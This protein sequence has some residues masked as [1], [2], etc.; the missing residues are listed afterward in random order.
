ML[1]FVLSGFVL[2]ELWIFPTPMGFLICAA[3]AVSTA[4]S[5]L[6]AMIFGKKSITDWA[7]IKRLAPLLAT[8]LLGIAFVVVFAFYRAA[9]IQ[10]GP[11][12][13]AL[14]G[15]V[16]PLLKLVLKKTAAALVDAGGNPD[17]APYMLF[18]LDAVSAM[19]GNFL[20]ISAS[21]ISSVFSMI[22][23]D[24]MENLFLALR[25]VFQIQ[26]SRNA[27]Q[28]RLMREKDAKLADIEARQA[29]TEARQAATEARLAR[30]ENVEVELPVEDGDIA[31]ALESQRLLDVDGCEAAIGEEQL[32]L[33]RACRLLLNFMAS[34]MSEMVSSAWCMIMLPMLYYSPHKKYF[35][36]I[37]ELDDAGFKQAL[38]FSAVDF[39]LEAATFAAMLLVFSLHANINVAA[40]GVE[41]VRTKNLFLPIL[42]FGIVVTCV[43]FAFFQKHNGMDPEFKWDE[44]EGNA[45]AT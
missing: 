41:Y 14:F 1:V 25:L 20:F 34:E 26:R 42:S 38:T 12:Q 43:S 40:V 30:L 22:S 6:F 2:G 17:A 7:L 3:P 8:A 36:T 29:A 5:A 21:G 45:T 27:T 33:H 37:D 18:C 23:V 35:Y 31:G 9:F 10:M 11:G 24:V 15:P 44:F 13:Q 32:H 39:V 4:A 19:C 16:W 28:A